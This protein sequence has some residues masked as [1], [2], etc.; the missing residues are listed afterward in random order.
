[1]S[2][3][4]TIEIILLLLTPVWVIHFMIIL[5][6]IKPEKRQKTVLKVTRLIATEYYLW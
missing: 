3:F 2:I 1:M 6:P 5:H 4:L